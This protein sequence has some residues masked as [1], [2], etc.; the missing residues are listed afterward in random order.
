M[1]EFAEWRDGFVPT[2]YGWNLWGLSPLHRQGWCVWKG[3]NT[4]AI[5]GMR[6][7]KLDGETDYFDVAPAIGMSGIYY[8]TYGGTAILYDETN[9]RFVQVTS[10]MNKVQKAIGRGKKY[11]PLLRVK[12]LFICLTRCMVV[13]GNIY[14]IERQR[15]KALDI[16]NRGW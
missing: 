13:K 14:N 8:N 10:D 1:Y 15:R 7:N 6:L 9:Q 12:V 16:W 3:N 11:F 5:Y 4:G 2:L